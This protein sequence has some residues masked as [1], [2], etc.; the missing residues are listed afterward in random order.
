MSNE[1]DEQQNGS[2]VKYTEGCRSVD[3]TSSDDVNK[4]V[5]QPKPN[6]ISATNHNYMQSVSPDNYLAYLSE[7]EIS[8]GKLLSN[9]IFTKKK[10][11]TLFLM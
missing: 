6:N 7:D 10:L 2:V 11:K 9:T 4:D 3:S 8:T 1:V 5:L